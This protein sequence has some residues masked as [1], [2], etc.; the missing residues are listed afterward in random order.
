VAVIQFKGSRGH[1][2]VA[3]RALEAGDE[4]V[5]PFNVE[6]AIFMEFRLFVLM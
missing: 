5:E 6:S 4:G 3:A 2:F 1:D